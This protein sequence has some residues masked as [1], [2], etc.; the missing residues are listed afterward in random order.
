MQLYILLNP[1]K[2]KITSRLAIRSGDW[3]LVLHYESNAVELFNLKDDPGE[4]K[5]V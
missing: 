5:D 4:L 2:L 3:K 1:Y